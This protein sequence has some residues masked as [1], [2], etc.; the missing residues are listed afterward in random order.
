MVSVGDVDEITDKQLILL[1]YTQNKKY[2]YY[3]KDCFIPTVFDN[4]SSNVTFEDMTINLQLWS[5]QRQ[6]NYK[7]LRPLS[8][9][10][11]D[12]FLICFS[13][14]YPSSLESV[15]NEWLPEIRE[16][17]P[18]TPF[19]LVGTRSDYRDEFDQHAE[20]YK[21]RGWEPIA[22]E[23]GLEMKNK[24][25]GNDYIECSTRTFKN[26]TKVFEAAMNAV[27]HPQSI[28]PQTEPTLKK[29]K[30]GIFKLFSKKKKKSEE[31]KK[32]KDAD[33]SSKDKSQKKSKIKK[34][35][36]TQKDSKLKDP[37]VSNIS[38]SENQ[39]DS[40][41]SNFAQKDS[42][43]SNFAQKDSN[44][45]NFAQKDSNSSNFAQKDSNSSNFAQKD[46]NSSNFAQK[47]SN[48]SN[49]TQKDSKASNADASNC[50][51]NTNQ[52]DSEPRKAGMIDTS[53]DTKPNDLNAKK[54]NL[55]QSGHLNS[56]EKVSKATEDDKN[57][58]K[59]QPKC[60][61][62]DLADFQ[63]ICL[64][65]NGAFSNVWKA[66]DKRTNKFCAAKILKFL[67]DEETRDSENTRSTFREVN[68]M[69][70]LN[71]PSIL[72]F[73]GYSP[74]NFENDPSP[75]IIID[76]ASNGSLRDIY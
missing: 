58:N 21:A 29:K 22:Y 49:F 20:E 43:P 36:S 27:I 56:D 37:S 1:S 64:I 71:H 72:K 39:K 68:L 40:N 30:S 54:Q 59:T 31:E 12:I 67:V 16:H 2:D 60:N 69:S 28:S 66:K 52:K 8:Y 76:Y 13:L 38:K 51:K 11:T 26:I 57:R 32:Q 62:L 10:Q 35:D 6:E 15:E 5:T 23:K 34:K 47:D 7:K 61:F 50:I 41:S 25:G 73:I 9:P 46:S 53:K 18:G 75:T 42:K 55:N 65:G 33:N 17:C 4:Y 63:L 19:I 48:S 3:D 24:L 14:V 45:S 44:S 70:L 74:V